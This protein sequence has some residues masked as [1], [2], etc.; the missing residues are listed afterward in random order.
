M[1][2]ANTIAYYIAY[3]ERASMKKKSFAAQLQA[4]FELEQ[5]FFFPQQLI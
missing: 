4:L 5:K 1:L 2:L 3:Y